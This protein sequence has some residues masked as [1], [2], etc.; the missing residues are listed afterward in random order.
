MARRG[1]GLAICGGGSTIGEM[2]RGG[3]GGVFPLEDRPCCHSLST[4]TGEVETATTT[5]DGEADGGGPSVLFV[6][7]FF[8]GGDDGGWGSS[9]K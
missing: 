4:V 3:E 5:S 8:R 6:H 7:V 9:L 1:G 2:G